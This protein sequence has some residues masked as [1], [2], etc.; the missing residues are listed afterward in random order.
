[1]ICQI[2]CIISCI[3]IV[4]LHYIINIIINIIIIIIIIIIIHHPS[5]IIHHS[6]FIIHHSSF[7][8]H[9]SS[10]IIHHPSSI[11]IIIIIKQWRSKPSN[12]PTM[13][14]QAPTEIRIRG[15]L[16]NGIRM[17]PIKLQ[18]IC[19]EMDAWQKLRG[20]WEVR[21]FLGVFGCLAID[22]SAVICVRSSGK[23]IQVTG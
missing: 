21:V 13:Q 16:M 12:D 10:F 3:C 1:M 23:I 22:G 20:V 5:S 4:S 17:N 15:F 7:I 2:S 9:H 14:V 11:I 6:S 8:I 19:S 18:Q